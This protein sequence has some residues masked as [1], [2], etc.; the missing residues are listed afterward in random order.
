MRRPAARRRAPF[1]VELPGETVNGFAHSVGHNLR[2]AGDDLKRCL[3]DLIAHEPVDLNQEI[4]L[5]RYGCEP[6]RACLMPT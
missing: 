5:R 1:E 3:L 4:R 6:M 2:I